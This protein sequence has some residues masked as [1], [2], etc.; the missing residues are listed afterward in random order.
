MKDLYIVGAGG[1]GRELLNIILDI[2]TI[3]GPQW[4]IKGF[5]DDTE[6][7]LAG[8]QCDYPVVGRIADYYPKTNEV[9]AMGIADPQAK[10]DLA[11]LLKGRGCVFES[12]YHPHINGGRHNIAG[13]GCVIYSG[14]GMT[15]NCKIGDF[16]TIQAAS[17]G[18]D[19]NI[20]DYCTISGSCN[21]MG[22][23][24][25]GK[26]VFMGGNCAIA[27]H[28]A[29]GEGAYICM[30]SMVMKDVRSGVKVMGNPAREIGLANLI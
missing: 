21:L 4:N 7:P 12:V 28:V 18:H 13:E 26:S 15:V 14:F 22:G 1:M 27:P 29:V 6:D 30:G 11:G 2:H 17:I 8:K 19:C 10:K 24:T 25:L 9:L 23:V 20:G 5:L 16:C 3:K